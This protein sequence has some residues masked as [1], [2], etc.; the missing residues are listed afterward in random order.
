ME[1]GAARPGADLGRALGHRVPG[2]AHRVLGDVPALPGRH[3]RRAYR[4]D[5][6]A[7]PAPRGRAGAVGQRHRARGGPALGARRAPAVRGAQDGQVD[8]ERSAAQRSGRARA[9]PAGAAAGVHRAPV[10]AAAEPDLEHAGSGRRH[11]AP[12]AAAGGRVGQLAQPAHVRAVRGR[13]P[14]RV[15]RRPGHP[16]RAARA[17]RRGEGQRDPA[18][19]QVRDVRLRRPVARPGSGPGHRPRAG[20]PPLPPGAA[21]AARGPGGRPAGGRLA[22]RGPAPR[23]A[24][25]AGR[26]GPGHAGRPGLDGRPRPDRGITQRFAVVAGSS[27]RIDG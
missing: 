14:R 26:H 20:G 21:D 7:L 5:R 8:P 22:G 15:R 10:P 25:H 18:G 12:V 1:G 11:R 19:R 17:A 3:H 13:L 23:R 16:G 4:R 6:P 27:Q 9:G 2:L 24:G